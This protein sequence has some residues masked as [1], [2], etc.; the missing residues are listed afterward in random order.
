MSSG[1]ADRRQIESVIEREIDLLLLMALHSSPSFRAFVAEKAADASELEFIDAWRGVAD[2]T[3][4]SDLCALFK[5]GDGRRLAVLI[6]DKIDAAFQ[7]EQAGR[8]RKRG[9]LGVGIGHWDR[10][11]TCLCAP[12]RYA[13]PLSDASEW[14]AV[15]TYEEIQARLA[16]SGDSFAPFVRCVLARAIDQQRSGTFA[17]NTAASAF[18]R[19]YKRFQRNDFPNLS[20]T[21]VGEVQS[22]NEPWPRFAAGELPPDVLLEHKAWKGC[23]DLTFKG[24][25][26]EAL[27]QRLGERLPSGCEIARVGASAAVRMRVAEISHAQPFAPQAKA[28]GDALRAVGVLLKLWRE[29]RKTAGSAPAAVAPRFPDDAERRRPAAA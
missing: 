7:P 27:R 15:V 6:E 21:Y 16:A 14:D 24:T 9:V 8:Y 20:I 5:D 11:V 18:W 13:A 19:E 28:V 29:L 25:T 12:E 1:L 2:Q 10:F 26:C 4:E 3:G 22:I 17:P 23:V